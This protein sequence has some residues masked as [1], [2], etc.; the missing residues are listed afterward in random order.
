[1]SS[2]Q[3]RVCHC[4]EL[5]TAT[6]S[7]CDEFA[8]ATSLSQCAAIEEDMDGML[9]RKS[10]L[11]KPLVDSWKASSSARL[12]ICPRSNAHP[13]CLPACVPAC[14]PAHLPALTL[15]GDLTRACPPSCLAGDKLERAVELGG[16]LR[17]RKS[18]EGAVRILT[19]LN[20]RTA[21]ERLHSVM[22]VRAGQGR[23]GQGR[24]G[25]GRAGLHC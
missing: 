3:R 6:S 2:A 13:A 21:A 16:S 17:I 22:E 20:Q 7:H 10:K 5:G 18:L 23:A 12:P 14:H 1:M 8:T 4:D 25:Q 24:A 9:L 15:D 11:Q 19:T